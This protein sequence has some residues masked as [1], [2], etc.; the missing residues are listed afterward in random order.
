[1][2]KHFY[3][4]EKDPFESHPSPDIFFESRAHERGWQYLLQ[5]IAEENPLLLVTGE[6]GA[7]K[8][9]LCLRLLERIRKGGPLATI[10]IADP[11]CGFPMIL[12]KILN[13][14]DIGVNSVDEMELQT[15]LYHYL[16][17]D[18]GA[19]ERTIYL[20]IDDVQECNYAVLNKLRMLASY[21]HM[22]HFPFK[23]ILFG[24]RKIINILNRHL[25]P[26]RQRIR[27]ICDIPSLRFE[28]VKEYI[29]FRLIHS[30]AGGVPVFDDPSIVL[31]HSISRGVPR[32]INNICDGCLSFA[33]R[34]RSDVVDAE[35]VEAWAKSM[36]LSG[37]VSE[38]V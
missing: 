33:A 3:L 14:L 17:T 22:G 19:L 13:G 32:L 5:G 1:M 15:C 36:R 20:V 12:T 18:A 24:H 7:G 38:G 29:Y 10:F 26:L 11:G 34:G 4:M 35:M 23:L 6:Y 16:E 8:T 25:V 30:G 21:N 37:D 2:Y 27:K 31:I 28:E 9:L